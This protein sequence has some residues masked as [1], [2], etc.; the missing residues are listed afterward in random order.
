[1]YFQTLGLHPCIEILKYEICIFFFN[2]FPSSGA[3]VLGDI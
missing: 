3:K 1:M 2:Y